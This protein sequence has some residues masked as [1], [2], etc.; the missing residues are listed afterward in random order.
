MKVN[1]ILA[2]FFS[3]GSDVRETWLSF[4]NVEDKDI[5]RVLSQCFSDKHWDNVN[6]RNT[7]ILIDPINSNVLRLHPNDNG[8]A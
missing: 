5:A 1:I 8:G 3:W 4:D 7:S 2:D 6:Y